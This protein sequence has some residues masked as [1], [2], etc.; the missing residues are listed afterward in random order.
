[1]KK[2]F[3][4][5]HKPTKTFFEENEGGVF[6]VDESDPFTSFGKRSDA[7]EA[8]SYIKDSETICDEISGNEYPSNEFEIIEL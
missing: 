6:L 7:E 1:M 8:L 5:W 4:I 2:R 3:A